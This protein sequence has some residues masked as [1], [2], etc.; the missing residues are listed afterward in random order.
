M[1]AEN[2]SYNPIRI[3]E[4]LTDTKCPPKEA[5]SNWKQSNWKGRCVDP[6]ELFINPCNEE[7]RCV[8]KD[9]NPS[10]EGE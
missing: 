9:H 4:C 3:S 1:C 5:C 8:V 7:K 10:C 6:C 2:S